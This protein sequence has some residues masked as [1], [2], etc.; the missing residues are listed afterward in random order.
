MVESVCDRVAVMYFG[1]IAELGTA[2]G[3]F[4]HPRHPYT[5][6]LLRSA[7][8]PGRRSLIPEDA[9]T[10]LPDPYNPPPGCAFFARCPRRTARCQEKHPPLESSL[11]EVDHLA[12]CYHPH[13]ESEAA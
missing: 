7:P 2:R 3:V 8:A 12:A 6:L 4:T 10:E 9:Q 5:H 1:R 13:G 11:G